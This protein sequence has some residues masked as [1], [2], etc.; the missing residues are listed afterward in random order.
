MFAW[1]TATACRFAWLAGRRFQLVAPHIMNNRLSAWNGFLTYLTL[2]FF[3]P[4][5]AEIDDMSPAERLAWCA[6]AK[7]TAQALRDKISATTI[8]EQDYHGKALRELSLLQVRLCAYAEAHQRHLAAAVE[9]GAI[10]SN[11]EAHRIVQQSFESSY[12]VKQQVLHAYKLHVAGTTRFVSAT[13]FNPFTRRYL[14]VDANNVQAIAR[15]MFGAEFEFAPLMGCRPEVCLAVATLCLHLEP[16]HAMGFETAHWLRAA[17]V[18]SKVLDMAKL[19]LN[20][21]SL[22]TGG[23]SNAAPYA[24][25]FQVA[26]SPGDGLEAVLSPATVDLIRPGSHVD[27]AV[28]EFH[29]PPVTTSLAVKVWRQVG[30]ELKAYA[31]A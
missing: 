24:S 27:A 21:Q 6:L 15:T 19:A 22:S 13:A 17:D 29:L 18:W 5:K 14:S 30:A 4:T 23:N 3:C 25:Q 7:Q 8:S 1:T 28:I 9:K 11:E 2:K 31:C 10:L 26:C 20:P 16:L 12:R